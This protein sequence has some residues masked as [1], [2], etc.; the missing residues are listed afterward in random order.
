MTNATKEVK[1]FSLVTEAQVN[2]LKNNFELS[3]QDMFEGCDDGYGIDYSNRWLNANDNSYHWSI[4]L[5]K[6]NLHLILSCGE[7]CHRV[8]PDGSIDDLS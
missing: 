4:S 3:D 6:A 7:E 8:N 5:Y 1:L 2:T